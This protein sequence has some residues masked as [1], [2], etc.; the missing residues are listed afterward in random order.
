MGL[1]TKH[2]FAGVDQKQITALP[3]FKL[4]INKMLR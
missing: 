4:L 1:E 2:D 3:V